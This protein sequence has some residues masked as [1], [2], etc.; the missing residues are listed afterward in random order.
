MSLGENIRKIREQRGVSR[1]K[2]A[3]RCG[4]TMQTL[5]LIETDQTKNPG[6]TIIGKVAN[7]LETKGE[8]DNISTLYGIENIK[9]TNKK[10]LSSPKLATK[11]GL[12][13]TQKSMRVY[14]VYQ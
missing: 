7:E 2:L 10:D 5:Y 9:I 1:E 4:I 8:K 12:Q 13:D 11:S 6:I 14:Q 3:S